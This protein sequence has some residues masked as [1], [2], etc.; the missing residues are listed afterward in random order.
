MKVVIRNIVLLSSLMVI[1]FAAC[2]KNPPS[3]EDA[4]IGRRI[5]IFFVDS[6]GQNVVGNNH[7]YKENDIVMK[8]KDSI[9]STLFESITAIYGK[10]LMQI[11]LI[12]HVCITHQL[13]L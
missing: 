4:F 6:N 9:L 10:I 13:V 3:S 5:N 12:C 11:P 8:M 2:R 1:L 7:L